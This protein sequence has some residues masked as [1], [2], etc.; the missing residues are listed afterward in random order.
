MGFFCYKCNKKFEV[1][2][3]MCIC[4]RTDIQGCIHLIYYTIVT[5]HTIQIVSITRTYMHTHACLNIYTITLAYTQVNQTI[6]D[7]LER[8]MEHRRIIGS[9]INQV[10][11]HTDMTARKTKSMMSKLLIRNMTNLA[12]I[13]SSL[14]VKSMSE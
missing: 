3:C 9:M 13:V 7:A 14:N 6:M 2:P 1:C 5:H 4:M 12:T 10:I 8:N 11:N